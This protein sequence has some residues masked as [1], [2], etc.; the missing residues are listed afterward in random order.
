MFRKYYIKQMRRF[1]IYSTLAVIFFACSKKEK[2]ISIPHKMDSF[3][4]VNADWKYREGFKHNMSYVAP[5]D[6]E[7]DWKS[8]YDTLIAYR[9]YVLQNGGDETKAFI[10][11]DLGDVNAGPENLYR[12][13]GFE[14]DNYLAADIHLKPGNIV[15]LNMETLW[16]KGGEFIYISLFYTLHGREKGIKF[17][18]ENLIDSIEI[19]Q[20]KTW[21]QIHKELI[22]PPF[23][24]DSF[25]VAPRFTIENR[26]KNSVHRCLIRNISFEIPA[27]DF[28]KKIPIQNEH[29]KPKMFNTQIYDRTDL[30]WMRENFLMGFVFI[31][32][33][34]FYD[35]QNRRYT[36]DLYCEKMKKEF[37]G[38]NSVL[39]WHSYP[40]IGVDKR[41]QYEI[42][43]HMPGGKDSLRNAIDKFHE[44]GVKVFIA[45]TPWDEMTK[46]EQYPD[47]Y[48]IAE[49]VN[50]LMGKRK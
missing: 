40:H 35:Y 21:H 10:D 27:S 45:Y 13:S 33:L 43:E 17:K 32:D 48:M 39:L 15:S 2:Y 18:S 28:K 9:E 12:N 29:D 8:W 5:P 23:N 1:V 3:N 14:L 19:K 42:F 41:N 16:K 37:G 25:W 46:R 26:K 49:T 47:E 30:T 31:W 20:K 11:M 4:L 50:G 38:F 22:I 34:D 7:N 36:V 6:H 24:T 44:N